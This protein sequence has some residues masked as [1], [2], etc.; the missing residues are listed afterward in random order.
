MKSGPFAFAR[1]AYKAILIILI[2]TWYFF[3]YQIVCTPQIKK[4]SYFLSQYLARAC[5]ATSKA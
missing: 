4:L 1:S 3:S 5:F 2:Q